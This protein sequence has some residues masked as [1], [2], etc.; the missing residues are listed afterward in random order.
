MLIICFE[1]ANVIHGI[2]DYGSST[3]LPLIMAN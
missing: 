2:L 3:I 1:L